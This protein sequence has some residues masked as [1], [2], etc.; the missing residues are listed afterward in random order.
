MFT[1]KVAQGHCRGRSSSRLGQ[2]DPDQR[3]GHTTD[4]DRQQL[5]GVVG[6][7]AHRRA[8]S[9]RGPGGVGW[10]TVRAAAQETIAVVAALGGYRAR[11][12]PSPCGDSLEAGGRWRP[13]FPTRRCAARPSPAIDEK[14]LNVEATAVFA[15]LAP[16]RRAG[17]GTKG[18]GGP[19]GGR[20]TTSTHWASRRPRNHCATGWRCTRRWRRRWTPGGAVTDW[21]RFHP[22]REDGGYLARLV[23]ACQE[24]L[25]ALPS[26]AA[27]APVAGRA[28]RR[29][30]EG[31]SQTHAAEASGFQRRARGL[32]I[33][34]RVPPGV[35][36]WWEAAAGASSS[37]AVHALIAAAADPRPSGAE[38]EL[39]GA[40]YF[41]P[42]G[43]LTVLLDDL[44]RPRR[45][46]HRR[47][48][49]LS[50]LLRTRET[51]TANRLDLL[52]QLGRAAISPLRHRR[53]HA[54]IL[55]GVVG[56]YLS[57]PNAQAPPAYQPP[58]IACCARP[59]RR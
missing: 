7:Q 11:I 15:T 30:G 51:E 18:D 10:R 32:G 4:V 16:R 34:P 23:A 48:P 50:R 26:R 2:A 45:G 21:Y 35:Y 29:C 55:A 3:S 46:R 24:G 58:A 42:I 12:V 44:G 41:P 9:R 6:E 39:I 53:R 52:A 13:R 33:E 56:F 14:G 25:R 5:A 20:S 31:Q 28:A 27:I 1:A 59:D 17:G 49:Q 57:D 22:Q 54:A 19:A 47:R 36:K 43:A 38:A 8:V 37:V 40:A